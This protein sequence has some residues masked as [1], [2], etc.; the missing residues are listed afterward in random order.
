MQQLFGSSFTK[1]L[2][3]GTR[4]M[5]NEFSIQRK[6]NFLRQHCSEFQDAPLC[7][8]LYHLNKIFHECGHKIEHLG[9]KP[10]I[11]T[12]NSSFLWT[13][14]LNNCRITSLLFFLV[15]WSHI[16]TWCEGFPIFW[17]FLNFLC[18]FQNA[19]KTAGMTVP[20]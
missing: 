12:H 9:W 14:F 4:K 13:L 16:M 7:T 10:C 3:L 19:V 8:I 6:W 15:T 5:K 20:S 1:N 17:F 2:I 18:L 11:F